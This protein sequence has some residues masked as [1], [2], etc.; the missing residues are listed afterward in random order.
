MTIAHLFLGI[1]VNIFYLYFCLGVIYC[2]VFHTLS[3]YTQ[4][5]TIQRPRCQGKNGF[6]F[7]KFKFVS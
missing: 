5:L 6:T 2:L 7:G 1:T 3:V 4:I